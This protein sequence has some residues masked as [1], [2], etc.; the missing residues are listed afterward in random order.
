MYFFKYTFN[1]L[2]INY[3]LQRTH[4]KFRNICKKDNSVDKG[5]N[6]LPK[7]NKIKIL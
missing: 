2:R 5:K 4:H 6:N 3:I 1:D 7:H